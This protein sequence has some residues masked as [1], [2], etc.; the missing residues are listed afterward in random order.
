M[1]FLVYRIYLRELKELA[2]DERVYLKVTEHPMLRER[3]S[4]PM[5][6][7]TLVIPK[8]E[9]TEKTFHAIQKVRALAEGLR[10]VGISEAAIVGRLKK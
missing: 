5:P 1:D 6:R 9:D 8:E 7:R 4:L 2:H 3:G 10:S